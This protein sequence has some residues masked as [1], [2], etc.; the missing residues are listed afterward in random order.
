[1]QNDS[2]NQQPFNA[3]TLLVTLLVLMSFFLGS[4]WTKVQYLENKSARE[5]ALAL[6][7]EGNPT[8]PNNIPVAAQPP[9]QKEAETTAYQIPM[10]NTNSSYHQ[11]LS[12][13]LL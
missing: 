10:M 12:S 1:M 4:L 13:V 7:T 3:T 8:Q 5:A 2:D 11:F 6:G 9:A